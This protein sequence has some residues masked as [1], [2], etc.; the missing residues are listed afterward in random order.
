MKLMECLQK[1]DPILSSH[2]RYVGFLE[3]SPNGL[4][5]ASASGLGVAET[6]F[7]WQSEDGRRF[8]P[9]KVTTL[10]REWLNFP[11]HQL[12]GLQFTPDSQYLDLCWSV[13][14]SRILRLRTSGTGWDISQR[15]PRMRLEITETWRREL[16]AED[17]WVCSR[18]LNKRLCWIPPDRRPAS[19]RYEGNY[20]NYYAALSPSGKFT[21]LDLSRLLN[22]A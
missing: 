6:I 10:V 5:I 3:Y 8:T 2:L 19:A 12:R 7:V 15:N 20:K 1:T 4:C 17:G 21:L 14:G 16:Y 18:S 22:E 13:S 11:I 9:V